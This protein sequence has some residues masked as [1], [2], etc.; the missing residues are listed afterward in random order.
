[1]LFNS[2]VFLFLFLPVAY[3]GFWRLHT[4]NQRYIWLTVASYI[5]YGTW[6]YKFCALMAFSTAVSY[7]AGLAML[8]ATN[9]RR[10][11]L[12][13][14]LPVT[15]DLLLLGFFKYFNFTVHTFAHLGAWVHVPIA[16]P[17]LN[18]ILP[19]G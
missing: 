1:M 3:F 19:V 9:P 6:N 8:G 13:L 18:I 16:T 7:L 10:R 5:F 17:S 12:F 14:A 15:I 2:L 4:K 11:K